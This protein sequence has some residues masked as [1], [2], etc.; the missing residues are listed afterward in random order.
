MSSD[1]NDNLDAML[2]DDGSKDDESCQTS[3]T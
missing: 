2:T 3:D 1:F